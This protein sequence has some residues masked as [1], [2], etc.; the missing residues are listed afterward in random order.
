MAW[1]PG[2][3]DG[4]DVASIKFE[5]KIPPGM[6]EGKHPYDA[7]PPALVYEDASPA[8][9]QG[10]HHVADMVSTLTW[11]VKA[12]DVTVQRFEPLFRGQP[13][14]PLADTMSDLPSPE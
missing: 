8:G 5:D 1:G 13:V 6:P 7:H 4:R 14:Q 2:P 9:W 12:A 10:V 3:L 11:V